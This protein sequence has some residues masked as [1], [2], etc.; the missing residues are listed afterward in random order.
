VYDIVAQ[1][2]VA[3]F[4]VAYSALFIA[5]VW[6]ALSARL[7]LTGKN[8]IEPVLA[9]VVRQRVHSA[10]QPFLPVRRLAL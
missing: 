9:R 6:W 5:L 4:L 2:V 8:G 1:T 10:V 7:S 3:F